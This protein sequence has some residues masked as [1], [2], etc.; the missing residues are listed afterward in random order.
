MHTKCQP[1]ASV[2]KMISRLITAAEHNMAR[3]EGKRVHLIVDVQRLLEHSLR[4]AWPLLADEGR[5]DP[6][7]G[8]GDLCESHTVY[9]VETLQASQLLRSASMAGTRSCNAGAVLV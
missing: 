6:S 2:I 3:H 1:D 9:I 7:R 4:V 8:L 5:A